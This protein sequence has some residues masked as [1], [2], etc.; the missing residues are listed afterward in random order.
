MA[1]MS[2]VILM[3]KAVGHALA[4]KCSVLSAL[5]DG[6]KCPLPNPALPKYCGTVRFGDL[7][8]SPVLFVC[9]RFFCCGFSSLLFFF[10]IKDMLDQTLVCKTLASVVWKLD[11]MTL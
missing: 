1:L 6:G 10:P 3:V 8:F 7:F 2:C 11:S 9:V 5:V 4:L